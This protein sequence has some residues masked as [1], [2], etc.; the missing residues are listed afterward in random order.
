MIIPELANFCWKILRQ[1]V[2][3]VNSYLKPYL[4][5]GLVDSL[6]SLSVFPPGWFTLSIHWSRLQMPTDPCSDQAAARQVSLIVL[7]LIL[8]THPWCLMAAT[9]NLGS[10]SGSSSSSSSSALERNNGFYAMTII[11]L[12]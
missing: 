1:K 10:F 5:N 3:V 4:N 6:W 9:F 12:Y 2:V 11:K 7:N 8:F